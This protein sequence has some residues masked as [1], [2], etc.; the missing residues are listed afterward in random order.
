MPFV[1]PA[2]L[3]RAVIAHHVT[4]FAYASPFQNIGL[5]F[6]APAVVVIPTHQNMSD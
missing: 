4:R 2:E 1:F 6:F 5:R 3:G